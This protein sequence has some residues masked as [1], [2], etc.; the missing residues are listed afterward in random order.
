MKIAKVAVTNVFMWIAIW[1]PYAGIHNLYQFLVRVGF[2]YCS[3]LPRNCHVGCVWRQKQDHPADGTVPLNGG[4]GSNMFQ[5]NRV[6][7]VPS[8]VSILQNSHYSFNCL[9]IFAKP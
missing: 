7:F 3:F 9:H 8:K 2:L 1:T 5:P 4:K 6:C